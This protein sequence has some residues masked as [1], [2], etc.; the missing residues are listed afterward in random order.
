MTLF[1]HELRA[2]QRLF[3]RSREL[4]FFTV[5]LPIIFFLLLGTVYDGEMDDGIR[6]ADYLLAGLMGYGAIATA[7]A[8]LAILLVIRRESGVLKRVRATP[9]P[10]AAYVAALLASTLVAFLLTAATLLVLGRLVFETRFPAE[11]AS[12]AAALLLGA[13]AFAALGV[14]L[15]AL[16]RSAEGASAVVNAIFLPMA[17]VSGAFFS[18]QAFPGILRALAEV[19]PLTHFIRLVR[20]TMLDGTHLWQEP[21]ALAAIAAWGAVGLAVAIRRF[22]W[23]PTEG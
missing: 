21:V 14:G 10:A 7:F 19:L 9:L 20:A 1:L 11:P 15:S 2:Q 8:G 6:A 4:A 13:A 12:F 17:F 5:A 16:I 3:W 18:P 22:R 23:E